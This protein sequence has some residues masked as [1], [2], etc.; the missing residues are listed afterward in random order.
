[1]YELLLYGEKSLF[2][3]K[4]RVDKLELVRERRTRGEAFK[5]KERLA[6]VLC[7]IRGERL[8]RDS[9]SNPQKNKQFCQRLMYTR[10]KREKAVALLLTSD[11]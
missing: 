4:A 5:V 1:M 9:F 6:A 10:I 11:H 8:I 2:F 7:C 3:S